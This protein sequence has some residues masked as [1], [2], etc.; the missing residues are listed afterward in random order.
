MP[1]SVDCMWKEHVASQGL[2]GCACVL[3]TAYDVT[4]RETFESLDDIWM[5]EV[6]MY[7][8]IEDSVKMVVANK[9][10]KV[11]AHAVSPVIALDE[12]DA[13]GHHHKCIGN[14]HSASS[15]VPISG[16][17]CRHPNDR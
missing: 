3:F 14:R 10:D 12:F 16:G 1:K 6:E 8:T 2:N 11:T 4:R 5:R 7:S 13:S 9:C 15:S 17:V